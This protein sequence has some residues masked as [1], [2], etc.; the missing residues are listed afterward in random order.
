MWRRCL[1]NEGFHLPVSRMFWNQ[2]EAV[3]A[4][5]SEHTKHY[6]LIPFK[7]V[8]GMV[9]E[10]HPNTLRFLNWNIHI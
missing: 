7:M 3:V 6:A 8:N 1:T 4:Q 2:L 5:L 9:Y 10:F